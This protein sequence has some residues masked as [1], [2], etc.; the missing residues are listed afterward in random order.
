MYEYFKALKTVPFNHV[1]WYLRIYI[2]Q[3]IVVGAKH[4]ICEQGCHGP[5]QYEADSLGY[6]ETPVNQIPTMC[7]GMCEN[8]WKHGEC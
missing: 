2:A 8:Y 4:C 3:G 5:G 6:G 1:F 7:I